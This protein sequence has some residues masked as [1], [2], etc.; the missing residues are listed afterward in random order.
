M[1]AAESSFKNDDLTLKDLEMIEI[2]W[3][4]VKD[5]QE[6]GVN[7]M[8]KYIYVYK[9]VITRKGFRM[10]IAACSI[11]SFFLYFFKNKVCA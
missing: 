6:L 8:I 4:F 3:S 1:G 5:K 9:W 2:S 11:L 10:Y 7:T